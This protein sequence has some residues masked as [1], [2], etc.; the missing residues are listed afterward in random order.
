MGHYNQPMHRV[1]TAL[2][3]LALSACGLKDD[4]YLPAPKQAAPAAAAPAEAA[5][6]VTGEKSK[7]DEEEAAPQP[8]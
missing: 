7:R 1:F 3:L 4:L 8:Q 5:P 2:A 6:P